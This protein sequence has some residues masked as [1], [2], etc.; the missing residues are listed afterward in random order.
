MTAYSATSIGSGATDD[1]DADASC[2]TAPAA[3]D[4]PHAPLRILLL[5]QYF[6]PETFLI[7][8]VVDDLRAL[9]CEVTVLTGQPNY[10]DG[11]I[12]TGYAAWRARRETHPHGYTVIRVPIVPRKKGG[13]RRVI[14]YASFIL[15]AGILGSFLLRGRR[16][17]VVFVYAVS[18]ILQV[19]PAI[20][21]SRL[22]RAALVVWVQ[23]LWPD[24][25][26]ST[27]AITHER[28]LRGVAKITR[29]I[30]RRCDLLLAQ[31]RGFV[32]KIRDL[33]GGA[34][35]IAVHPNPGPSIEETPPA[36]RPLRLEPGFNI[37]FAGNFGTA[38][39]M[40]TI[41][42]TA[43]L[44]EDPQCRFILV[45]SGSQSAWLEKEIDRR[46]L[47]RNVRLAGRFP[48]KTM[49]AILDEAS[50]L[51]VT[52]AR[53]ENLALTIPSKIPAYLAAGKPILGSL[54]GEAN[55]V[56]N[57]SG[58][59]I[60]VP[61]EDAPALAEAIGKLLAMTREQRAELGRAGRAYYET[62]FSP[63]ELAVALERHLRQAVT[64]KTN[65]RQK[66]AERSHERHES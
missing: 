5:T 27:G 35:P 38:Q 51:L 25:L 55:Q 1:D 14:N 66:K 26:V 63:E 33:A 60:A 44:I 28:V 12:F 10:P 11:D 37:V 30:Y 17:D 20:L 29:F 52:L 43:A 59:G 47:A 62:H 64:A 19:L 13:L 65:A 2:R 61:A 57:Q 45:G 23:D 18:P 53:S 15:S 22:K 16:F 8:D 50:A 58:A 48:S 7:N 39:S 6:W 21:V 31:S 36:D 49:P 3:R 41:L 34:V 46:R 42:D 9:G 54:D 56:I 4:G 32:A 24:T 40:E